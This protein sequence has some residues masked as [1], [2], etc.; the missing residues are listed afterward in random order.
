MR[1]H[2]QPAAADPGR[3]CC[4]V[5]EARQD[6]FVRSPRAD[7]GELSKATAADTFSDSKGRKSERVKT[8]KVKMGRERSRNVRKE[9]Q[10]LG[11]EILWGDFAPQV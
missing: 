5:L 7:Y 10:K 6:P 8:Q 9:A 1:Q 4:G 3:S 2:T 11:G